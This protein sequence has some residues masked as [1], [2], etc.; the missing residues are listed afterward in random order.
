MTAT[1]DPSHAT[2]APDSRS[3]SPY[4]Q[5]NECGHR[6]LI[7][8]YAHGCAYATHVAG[9]AAAAHEGDHE[10]AEKQAFTADRLLWRLQSIDDPESLRDFIAGAHSQFETHLRS[11]GTTVPD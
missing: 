6:H 8:Y 9:A 3:P 1:F 2:P 4:A 10:A 11:L 5:R 7:D